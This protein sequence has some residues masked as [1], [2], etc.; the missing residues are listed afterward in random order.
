MP[1]RAIDN[2]YTPAFFVRGPSP[3]A[4]LI[5]FAALSLSL[6]AT[7]SR[8][9]YLIEIR[10]GFVA[11][12]YPLQILANTPANVYKNTKDYFVTHNSLLSENQ[13]LNTQAVM[14]SAELQRFKS[15]ETENAHLRNLLDAAQSSAQP[16][17]M[18]EILHMGRD[19]FTHKVIVNL[20]S[21]NNI[22]EGQAVVDADGV[23]GQVTKVYPFSSEVTLITDK[24]LAI[25]VQVERNGLRA[26]A[27][28][29]GKDTRID[30]PYLPANVD[31]RKGDKLVT[32]GIDGV[33]PTGLAV[34]EV[35]NIERNPNS[36]FASILGKPSAGIENHKQLL[37]IDLPDP[38]A[39]SPRSVS[40]K[41]K[42]I[43]PELS[44][45]KADNAS[46]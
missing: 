13:R 21:R 26:I 10:Q 30:L 17:K 45:P 35:I 32:S 25:P 6:M 38:N 12:L 28:G 15:L 9:H 36:P 3:F 44:E 33:Y 34:A 7:D 19:P 29:H 20:G 39:M 5:F 37:L 42:P 14:Q 23:I 4:R 43:T 11:L 41:T 2:Q 24:E 27:F 8:L 16:A 40:K 1:R 22:L 46:R 18:G 31:I